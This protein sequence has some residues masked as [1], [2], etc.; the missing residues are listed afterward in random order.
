MYKIL[1]NVE[2]QIIKS[3]NTDD[4]FVD[5]IKKIASEND[6]DNILISNKIQAINYLQT[7]CSNLDLV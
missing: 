1:N 2:N 5:F 7:Y 4:E 3:F 6:D